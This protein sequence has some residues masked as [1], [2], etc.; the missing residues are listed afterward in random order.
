M[1]RNFFRTASRNIV[2][3]KAYSTINFIGLTCGLSLALLII[4]YVRSE[5]SFDQFHHNIENLYRIQYKAPN[6]LE[7][8]TSPPP[9][10]P[11]L[12]EYFPEV[13]AAGR[14]YGRNVSIS[15]P[16]RENTF[17]ET[18]VY[19]ADS[20][21]AKMMT[22]EFVRGN[23]ERALCDEFTVIIT[24]EMARKYFG[25]DNPLGET[26][27]FSGN[28][29]FK[30]T[31]VIKKFPENSHIRFNMLVPYEN[32]FDLESD[33]TAVQLRGNLDINFVISHSYTYVQLKPGAD[34]AVIDKGMSDFVKKYARPELQVGQVFS[35][36]PV[37]DIHLHSTLLAE[38]SSTNSTTNLIIFIGVGFLTLV[39]ACINYVNLSTAQSFTRIKEI[40]IRKILGSLKYQLIIQFL[41]ESFLFCLVAMMLSYVVF[42][43][44]LPLL[45]DLTGKQMIFAQV[46]DADLLLSSLILLVCITVMAG[47][48]PAYFITRF[49]SIHALKGGGLTSYGSQWFR[50]VLVVFQLF[51][52]CLLLSGSILI[53][54]QMNFLQSRPLGFRKEHVV[55]IPLFSQNLNGLFRQDDSTY[56]F[57]LETYR[58]LIERQAG[59]ERTALSSDAPGLGIVYHGVI[60]EGFTQD[61]NLFIAD[62]S[63]DYD[64]LKTYD[65]EII[66]GRGF[67]KDYGTDATEG[68]IVNETA[69]R[70]FNW[71]TPQQAVGK[72][73]NREGK[74]G[75]VV[76]VIRDFHFASLTTAISALVIEIN[77]NQF[78]TVSIRFDHADI[79]QTLDKLEDSWNKT[80][81]EKSFEFRFLDEQLNEQ[82]VDFRN[83]GTIIQSFTFIAIL[84]SCLG[85]YGLVLF[86]V[87]RKVKEIGVRKVMGASVGNILKMICRDFAWLLIIGFVLAIPVSYYLM[88]QWLQNFIYHTAM[89]AATYVISFVMV[90]VIVLLTISYQAVKASLANPVN[91]LRSE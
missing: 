86:V 64:F 75:K 58:N 29:S 47:G 52:A 74:K 48:Y 85:V 9:I 55:N 57:R 15:R 13:E 32:M 83:F 59:V 60:P 81:P 67:S 46:V 72:N 40:G 23:A 53:M 2:K 21:I 73:I 37:K 8:A 80:F 34:P 6:G 82:Y 50:K 41:A 38:P 77:P 17:E 84:I 31:G 7:L 33:E 51:I 90:L 66:S 62:M 18:D 63:V 54:K 69:V 26:L 42:Y 39:I 88:S 79:Q 19:F 27:I 28:H 78:N 20:A 89:D 24:E 43:V 76:G 91:S 65:V 36:M 22:L 71:G 10:A 25:D 16:D 44:T 12:K 68:F 87:Q 56:R 11:K 1:F 30:V 45:N 35:L 61:D 3:N 5:M 70:E 4:T 14:M 49:E